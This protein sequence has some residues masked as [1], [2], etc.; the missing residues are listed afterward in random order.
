MEGFDGAQLGIDRSATTGLMKY[1]PGLSKYR[2]RRCLAGAITT[3]ARMKKLGRILDDT[4]PRCGMRP[5]TWTHI[6]DACPAHDGIRYRDFSA[7]GWHTMPDCLR[8]RGLVPA[9]LALSHSR[10][11]VHGLAGNVQY[12]LLDFLTHRDTLLPGSL[13]PQ[14]RWA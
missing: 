5:E 12:T 8:L 14:P 1:L 13:Q 11:D 3:L 6:A 10:E 4:C 9:W 7:T 2:L